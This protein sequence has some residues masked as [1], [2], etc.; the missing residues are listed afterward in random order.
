M[1]KV[2]RNSLLILVGFCL[3]ILPSS[4]F[5]QALQDPWS[6]FQVDKENT[7]L[8]SSGAVLPSLDPDLGFRMVWVDGPTV[9]S[10]P[11]APSIPVVDSNGYVYQ[12]VNDDGT[13]N[14]YIRR[15]A[16]E[17]DEDG[18]KIASPFNEMYT[19]T[20]PD[21]G[22]T[23]NNISPVIDEANNMIYIVSNQ[24]RVYAYD[25]DLSLN[26]L[27]W[28]QFIRGEVNCS[29]TFDP[30]T[31]RLYV[32]HTTDVDGDF[33]NEGRLIC[34]DAFSGNEI[35]SWSPINPTAID[36]NYESN[37]SAPVAIAQVSDGLNPSYAHVYI[38][39]V[40]DHNEDGNFSVL[41]YAVQENLGS[42]GTGIEDW[43]WEIEA[44]TISSISADTIQYSAPVVVPDIPGSGGALYANVYVATRSGDVYMAVDQVQL[45]DDTT[46]TP[47]NSGDEITGSPAWDD[48]YLY[49]LT[50]SGLY[51]LDSGLVEFASYTSAGGTPI[52]SPALDMN[53]VVYFGSGGL[54]RALFYDPLQANFVEWNI[55]LTQTADVGSPAV[56]YIITD[57]ADVS[58][59]GVYVPET[60]FGTLFLLEENAAPA[61]EAY[62]VANPDGLARGYRLNNNMGIPATQFTYLATSVSDRGGILDPNCDD[63]TSVQVTMNS[64]LEYMGAIKCFYNDMPG[65]TQNLSVVGDMYLNADDYYQYD[66][67]I[68][69][70][71]RGGNHSFNITYE[72]SWGASTTTEDVIGPNMCPEIDELIASSMS[73]EA[74]GM[75][76]R[77]EYENGL[78][79]LTLRIKYFDIDKESPLVKNAY[80]VGDT[81]DM[82]YDKS[83]NDHQSYC[84]WYMI[85]TVLPTEDPFFYFE[86]AD[87][88]SERGTL[89]CTTRYPSVGVFYP[90][91]LTEPSVSPTVGDPDEV[92]T[93]SVRFFS[94]FNTE[95][96]EAKVF[97]NNDPVGLDMTFV[98][99]TGSPG[100]GVYQYVTSPGELSEGLNNYYFQ[101]SNNRDS[102]PNDTNEFIARTPMGSDSLQGPAISSWPLYRHDRMHSGKARSITPSVPDFEYFE[103]SGPIPGSAIVDWNGKIYFG[104]RDR[105]FYCLNPDLTLSWSFDTGNWIDSSATLGPNGTV[106]FPSRDNNIYCLLTTNTENGTT[107]AL[108]GEERLLWKYS[109]EGISTSS[110]IVA[111][112]GDIIVGSSYGFLYALDQNGTLNWIYDI[113]KA[114]IDGS[115]V[116]S[117]N[118]TIFFGATDTYFYAV[119]SSGTLKW[120]FKTGDVIKSTPLL[121]ETGGVVQQIIFTSNDR[122]V[123]SILDDGTTSTPPTMNWSYTT[124]AKFENSSPAL[125][126]SNNIY[127]AS[128]KVYNLSLTDGSLL[129]S[130]DDIGGGVLSSPVTDAADHVIFGSQDGRIYVLNSDGTKAWSYTKDSGPWASSPIILGNGDIVIGSWDGKLYK[131]AERTANTPP[132]LSNNKITP[133]SGNRATTF[134]Y[135]VEYF[136]ADGDPPAQCFLYI[137]DR[138]PLT[139]TFKSGQ[140]YDG[141]YFYEI[142]GLEQGNHTY[143]F[144]FTDGDWD[145]ASVVR[146]PTT[147]GATFTGPMVNDLPSISCDVQDVACV[148][149]DRGGR[150]TTFTFSAIYLDPDGGANPGPIG[151]V[152]IDDDD[153]SPFPMTLSS[154]SVHDGVYSYQTTGANLGSGY[155]TFYYIFEDYVPNTVRYPLTGSITGPLVNESP[156]LSDATLTPAQ[157]T[158]NTVFTYEIRYFDPDDDAVQSALVYIDGIP[159]EMT[160]SPESLDESI[161]RYETTLSKGNHNYYFV[162]TDVFDSVGRFP[163]TPPQVLQGPFV[164]QAPE[165]SE[166]TLEPEIGNESTEFY[167]TVHYLDEEGLPPKFHSVYVN[168]IPYDMELIA[169]ETYDGT[170]Q[171]IIKG[172]DIGVGIDNSYYFLFQN[173]IDATT[174]YPATGSFNGPTVLGAAINIPFWQV[175]PELDTI[176]ALNNIGTTPAQV[177]ISLVSK[178]G[179]E[180]FNADY[181][182][183]ARGQRTISLSSE[184]NI[185]N[186]YG[187]G[188]ITWSSG[189]LIAWGVVYNNATGSAFPIYF[190]LPRLSPIYIPYYTVDVF[191]ML[192]TSIFLTNLSNVIASGTISFYSG[193]GQL[194]TRESFTIEPGIM[195]S[196]TASKANIPNGI[197]GYAKVEWDQGVLNVFEA[198]YNTDEGYG[199][200]VHCYPPFDSG[201][202]EIS[203]WRKIYGPQCS[204]SQAPAFSNGIHGFPRVAENSFLLPDIFANPELSVPDLMLNNT[205]IEKVI[206]PYTLN[207]L[208]ETETVEQKAPAP[209]FLPVLSDG[210]VDPL[211]GSQTQP[212]LFRVHYYDQDGDPATIK[213]L[214]FDGIPYNMTL[215]SGF[216]DDGEY[217]TTLF[218]LS[219]GT[220]SFY[221][222]FADGVDGLVRYPPTGSFV[223]PIVADPVGF[224]WDTVFYITNTGT[225]DENADIILTFKNS[226][227]TTNGNLYYTGALDHLPG[228]WTQKIVLSDRGEILNG[229]G[230][231]YITW[232]GPPLLIFGRVFNNVNEKEVY[233]LEFNTPR[234]ETIYIPAWMNYPEGGMTTQFYITNKSD[235]E[236]SPF[237]TLFDASGKIINVEPLAPIVSGG[238]GIVDFSH[239][240]GGGLTFGTGY[241]TWD[242]GELDIYGQMINQVTEQYYLINFDRPRVH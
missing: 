84:D 14:G 194:F 55:Q 182:I 27:R 212:F 239:F 66:T 71:L 98:P 148:S 202:I 93:F 130:Y 113:G 131:I 238:T 145:T 54:L 87:D 204:A 120:K 83:S 157:G 39:G 61:G 161:Y 18:C 214:V 207:L 28:T 235:F 170:Y 143:Y 31:N 188:E 70:E 85:N 180:R 171:A 121:I 53:S 129:W 193:F 20:L 24:G 208:E 74:D 136:D 104:S 122:K 226:D 237:L 107:E 173:T 19:L 95:P 196:F 30:T 65:S 79:D 185:I 209:A 69:Q 172:F 213:N 35:Y 162:F 12:L 205:V 149:P 94:P 8:Y 23:F 135:S 36:Q 108:T 201:T 177:N 179:V 195:K 44:D 211:E 128:D 77:A 152:I 125:G 169:G 76:V 115:P 124:G 80:I 206:N 168:N 2:S 7:G 38:L 45:Y 217:T 109:A 90:L 197:E 21:I 160:A 4:L 181:T 192:D 137:D 72:D 224:C 10:T 67:I 119:T 227:G 242:Q 1:S 101:F 221:F 88:T 229:F 190:D 241:I 16:T 191:K 41:L 26:I 166:A 6:Q 46:V 118:G 175:R 100:N 68:T 232:D 200:S 139:M 52:T 58:F 105:K 111:P 5:A 40:G 231:G 233:T 236:I 97:I 126:A 25:L 103:T 62:G 154:G 187:Y 49:V 63:V 56:G 141:T 78:T 99:G 156:V 199:F 37:F 144:E 174:R 165:L 132:V 81:Y 15:L 240:F 3:L 183:P 60:E 218:D 33:V 43:A 210:R 186:N 32:V 34:Y 228:T 134:A 153:T 11:D 22:M 42:P 102:D 147:P 138:P 151:W 219:I 110:P 159:F 64:T 203:N 114:A 176:F 123:Y 184:T 189:S 13:D 106:V 133:A 158:T 117:S 17:F 89:S 234:E 51:M 75:E 225:T 9:G 86:F 59:Y 178:D 222:E 215:S 29:P 112:N 140:K 82:V 127:V 50:H 142:S 155:H 223:G 91:K 216:P 116:V 73:L 57:D 163:E 150:T 164:M 96:D 47:Y 92:F 146:Y 198:V 230:N 167:F 48:R 220:H